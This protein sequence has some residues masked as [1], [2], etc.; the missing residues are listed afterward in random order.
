[1]K[2][3]F[4]MACLVALSASG[5]CMADGSSLK[6]QF[7]Y[8]GAPP[9]AKELPA[10]PKE[11]ADCGDPNLKVMDESLVVNPASKGLANV[12]VYLNPATGGKKPPVP[13]GAEKAKAAAMVFDNKLLR[14]EPHVLV[15][16]T[17]QKVDVSNSDKVGHNTKIDFSG[18]SGNPASNDS[19]AAGAKVTKTYAKEERI[20]AGVSCSIHPYMKAYILVRDNPYF[21]VADKDGNFEI[22]DLPDGEWQFTVW[23]EKSGYLQKVKV[24]GKDV[25]WAKGKLTQKIA[26]K[27]VDLGK[28]MVSEENFKGK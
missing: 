2:R 10:Q 23:Q 5:Y 8:D 19:L 14:F 18:V 20:P 25:T 15:V 3:I 22:K 17:G 7:I 4:L 16:Q 28:I 12:I 13:A 9:A 27:P 11:K 26:G 21:A 1:M 6:G 24:G